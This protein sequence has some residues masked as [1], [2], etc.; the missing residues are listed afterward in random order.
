MIQE[1]ERRKQR[2]SVRQIKY[3]NTVYTNRTLL[4]FSNTI[5]H[6]VVEVTVLV[7]VNHPIGDVV[8]SQLSE[9]NSHKYEDI[10]TIRFIPILQKP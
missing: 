2:T 5:Q 10:S 8:Y 7:D 1:Q 4:A 3:S 9:L 6:P